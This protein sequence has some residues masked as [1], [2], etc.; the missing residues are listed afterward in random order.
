[1]TKI[2][3]LLFF[4]FLTCPVVAQLDGNLLTT[5][6]KTFHLETSSFAD[7]SLFIQTIKA[8]SDLVYTESMFTSTEGKEVP[9][10]VLANPKIS[11]PQEAVES[12]KTIVYIQGNI[13]GGEVEGK[14]A[15]MIL[16]REILFGDKSHLLENQIVLFAPIYNADG[17]DKFAPDNRRSQEGSPLLT[18]ERRSGGDYDLNRDGMKMEAVETQ[19]L[20]K[21]MIVKWNP[22]LFVDLHTTNGTWHGNSLT[23]APSYGSAGHPAT[24][25]YTVDVMLP[26]IKK[27]VLEKYDLHFG[28]YG[29]YTLREGWPPKNLYTYNHHPRY[30]VNQ[31]SFRNKMAILSETFAHDRFYERINAAH[32]FITEILEYTNTK[33]E[34]IRAINRR[35]EEE[36][37]TKIKNEG[38]TFTKGVRFKMIPTKEPLTLR[39]YDYIPYKDSVG[40]TRYAR[41]GNII[42]VEGV[43]NYNA[44]EATKTATVPRGYVIPAKFKSIVDKLEA[45]G[46]SIEKLSR[47][48]TYSGEQFLIEKYDVAERRFEH[49]LM[50]TASGTFSKKSYK[51]K[52][53]DFLVSME[54]PLAMLI[55]YLLE[56]ESD[57]GLVTWN[58]FDD[59][60][61]EQGI[62]QKSV[63][64]PI[65]KFW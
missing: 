37:L 61:N 20:M 13:H 46:V 23:Y 10:V 7:V 54:Q 33:G 64:Y 48:R 19:G 4:C 27:T 22:D 28:I 43:A 29:G 47:N 34:E 45:H 8:K 52:N 41:T 24:S 44:F 59:Y 2:F 65:F 3:T 25:E 32:K 39:T 38:G 58:F 53:G 9:L 11:S 21:N 31:F 36:T 42:D 1:M 51:A 6:E 57:D 26:A 35:S 17:N 30:L 40:N 12:G 5:P 56:P 63:V 49:H 55:F 62:G 60:L 15:V 14:E 16:M 50:A 18:G